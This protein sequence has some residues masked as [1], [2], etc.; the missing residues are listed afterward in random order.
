VGSNNLDNKMEHVNALI[1]K[2]S[3][4]MESLVLCNIARKVSGLPRMELVLNVQIIKDNR[5]MG[6]HVVLTNATLIGKS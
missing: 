6:S 3:L 2:E 1:T 5:W 4:R